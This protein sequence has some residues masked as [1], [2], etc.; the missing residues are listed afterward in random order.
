MIKFLLRIGRLLPSHLSAILSTM[1]QRDT[2]AY[3]LP[4]QVN[5]VLIY[6]RSPEEWA[7]LLHR[8]VCST[9]SGVL[10][11]P[12]AYFIEAVETG[13]LNTILTFYDITDPPME[14][15]FSGMP[16]PLL[17]KVIVILAK[18]GKAQTISISD[19]EGVRFFAGGK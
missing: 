15:P 13:Q 17:K 9:F 18:S 1:V 11:F 6:W 5:S 16:I 2:A 8:W 19:G 4:K 7:D 14:S 12:D 3:E 10:L